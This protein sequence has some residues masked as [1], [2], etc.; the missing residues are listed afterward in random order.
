MYLLHINTLSVPVFSHLSTY[1]ILKN[2]PQGIWAQ[3]EVR[4]NN[5][6]DAMDSERK[7][8]ELFPDALTDK[9]H[10]IRLYVADAVKQ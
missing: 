6:N 2:D 10:A 5:Q 3:L 9:N 8:A 7:V 4:S 1:W